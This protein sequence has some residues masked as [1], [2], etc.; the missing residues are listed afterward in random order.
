MKRCWTVILAA[1]FLALLFPFSFG[2]NKSAAKTSYEIE[3][4]LAGNV[5]TG[6]EKITFLNETDNSFTELKFNVYGNAAREG[7]KFSPIAAKDETRAYYAGKNYGKEEITAVDINGEKAEYELGGKDKN[8]LV[9]KL[10]NELFPNESVTAE[11]EF[12]LNLAKVIARTGITPETV[13]LANFYPILCGIEN[14]AFFECEYYSSGDPFFSDAADYKV[15]LTA[16]EKYCVAASGK[17]TKSKTENGKKTGT[18]E[19]DSARSFAFVLSERFESV[20]DSSAGTEINYYYYKDENPEKTLKTAVS[21]V[22]FFNEKFGEYPYPVYSVVQTPFIQGGMEFSALVYISDELEEKPYNEVVVHETAHQWWQ[23]AV[24][25]NEVKYGFLDEGL[26]EYS[27]VLFFEEHQDYG[28]TREALVSSA[29]KTYKTFCSVYDKLF[30]SVNTS[31]LRSLGEYSG[32][33]EYVNIAYIKPVI[34]YDCLRKTA[35]DEKFFKGLK[36]YYKDYKFK[37]AEPYDIAGAFE[38]CGVSASGF[39]EGFYEGKA[40]L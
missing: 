1:A 40:I 28:F 21:A 38:K 9:V 4:E 12:T 23:T 30:G 17:I 36:R 10:K 5:L 25:N 13:N 11:I 33:Y 37:I 14:G 2:C 18:Y 3:C 19:L 20:A 7:A 8:I 31:M 39:L 29:E 24:G 27:V 32:E 15:T 6:R 35:G 16:E 22:K 34:M 26:A